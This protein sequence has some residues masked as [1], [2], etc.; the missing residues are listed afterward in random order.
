MI[1]ILKKIRTYDD[2]NSLHSDILSDQKNGAT[3]ISFCNAHAVNLAQKN[4]EFKRDLLSSNFLFR[5]GSGIKIAMR[6]MN[7]EP[8]LNL[9]G[10]DFIPAFLD[11]NQGKTLAIFGTD[12]P[13]LNIA[14][15]KLSNTL[16]IVIT[17]NGFQDT[18]TYIDA[19]KEHKPDIILL[20]M[21]MP[22]QENVAR[23]LSEALDYPAIIINGGAIVDF[24]AN[25]FERAPEYMRDRGLEWVY[26][27]IKEPK[28]LFKR[29]I[30]GNFTFLIRVGCCYIMNRRKD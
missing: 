14:A 1:E 4:T 10:T 22:K 18:S 11:K 21:G 26:R 30:I 20:A 16:D 7:M 15:E 23:T 9:N 12:E 6:T 17:I 25:R 8:G 28:R 27:L 3:V 19:A 29:Y 13:W 5:D 2:I 24:V